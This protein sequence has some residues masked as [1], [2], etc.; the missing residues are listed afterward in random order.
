MAV[1]AAA[2]RSIGARVR[3]PWLSRVVI[4]G[5]TVR[6]AVIDGAVI[7]G[8]ADGVGP[9]TVVELHPRLSVVAATVGEEQRLASLLRSAVTGSSPGIH[10]EFVDAKGRELVVFRP[11]RG[12]ARVVEIETGRELTGAAPDEAWGFGANAETGSKLSDLFVLAQLDHQVI[13]VLANAVVEARRGDASGRATSDQV[14]AQ[15]RGWWR[16]RQRLSAAPELTSAQASWQAIAGPVDAAEALA[17]QPAAEA[18]AMVLRRH[19]SPP[20]PEADRT[21]L[22]MAAASLCPRP[23]GAPTVLVFPPP[24][25]APSLALAALDTLS[26]SPLEGGQMVIVSSFADVIDWGRLEAFAGRSRCSDVIAL[27]AL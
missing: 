14:P 7:D 4:D 12:R 21:S 9:A 13:W 27:T 10:A 8:S 6:G 23:D 18:C 5:A 26:V 17:W 15:Q 24:Q 20:T 22:A 3:G 1:D 25:A 16:R 2:N 11:Q 19:A